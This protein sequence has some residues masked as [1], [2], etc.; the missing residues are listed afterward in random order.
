MD[1]IFAKE[2]A[3]KYI[4]I[5]KKSIGEVVRKL[6]S[7]GIDS[8]T[9]SRVIENLKELDYLDDIK[10]TEAFVRQSVNMQKYSKFELKQKL[11]QKLVNIDIIENVIG[12]LVDED[13]EA[14][15]TKSLI[16]GKLKN[17]EDI[18]KKEYL[19]RRGFEKI[20]IEGD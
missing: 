10:Y 5:S 4:G 8:L 1:Y 11:L 18:K 12:R 6:K 7:L 3:I 15:V 13:Y 9:I 2:R 17:Y 14:R 19:Y 20:K 16:N